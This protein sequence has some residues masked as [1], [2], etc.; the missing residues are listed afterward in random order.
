MKQHISSSLLAF[1]GFV[2]L[3]SPTQAIDSD[4]DGISDAIES[5]Y[6]FDIN[7]ATDTPTMTM[8]PV[9]TTIGDNS[10]DALGVSVAGA[11][12][13]NNDGYDDLIIGAPYDDN[14]GTHSGSARVIS[15]ANYST[16]Y[17]FYGTSA[18]DEFG[19]SVSGAGDVNNDGYDDVIV[20]APYN[21]TFA[22][23]AGMV[24]IYSGLNGSILYTYYGSA[25]GDYFGFAVAKAGDINKD[26]Y[27]DFLIGAYGTDVNGDNSGSAYIYSGVNGSNLS[28]SRGGAAGD[29]YGGAVAYAGD[30]NSDTYPDV[31]I[32]ADSDDTSIGTDA[33]TAV[34]IS[35][36]DN[37]VIHSLNGESAED[38][39]GWSVDGAGDVNNDGYDDVI[40]GA[41]ADD[42][43]G[44]NSGSARVV[45]GLTGNT[46][47][48]LNGDTEFDSFGSSVAGIGDINDDGIVDIL[49]I[50][51][52]VNAIM[53][54]T[55]F[56]TIETYAA[57][58]NG[59]SNINIQDIIL[60]INLILS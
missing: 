28:V 14:S 45:S 35:G 18:D 15:G 40:I 29:F 47:Y 58:L 51:L 2:L 1:F 27:D 9:H 56:T 16:L 23:N 26:S 10:G 38:Q 24:R 37:T 54:T 42:N 43:N 22:S 34:V 7:D 49:D 59:D 50:V 57:D 33:G 30:V 6:G 5:L 8:I 44:N 21:D 39:F 36:F 13:V 53:G 46:L 12:D 32:G 17:T 11:G 3:A 55:E 19:T 25:S 4:S 48:T 52:L 41:W 31:I 20:G 60:T